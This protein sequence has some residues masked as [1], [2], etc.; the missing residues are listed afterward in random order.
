MTA[1]AL[2]IWLFAVAALAFLCLPGRAR[3][4]TPVSLKTQVS[5]REVEVSEPFTFTL[6]ALTDKGSS[7]PQ[8][9]SLSVPNGI[10]VRGPSVAMQQQVT[11]QGGSFQQKFGISATWTLEAQRP[12]R[13]R[14]GPASVS[15]GNQRASGDVIEIQVSPPGT[16][17]RPR[18]SD[19]FD[20]FGFGIPNLPGFPLG[21]DG[22]A[23]E[24]LPPF[25]EEL[26]LPQAEEPIAFLRAVVTPARAVVGQQVTLK[27]FAYGARGPFRETNTSEPSREA[28]LAHVIVENSYSETTHRVPIGGETWHA[29]KVR[30]VALFPIRTG[31]LVIGPMRMGFEGRGYP[32]TGP[33]R[34]LVRQSV[35]LTVEVVE[36]P[37]QRRPPGYRVG[38]VG[39]FA[40]S[41]NVEPRE[42]SAGDAVSVVAKLEGTGNL[43]L[44]LKTPQKTG[45]TWL[46]PTSVDEIEPRGSSIGGYR[47]LTYVV[48]IDTPGEVDLGELSLPYWD[49]ER[50]SYDV[51]KVPLGNVKVRPS[52][53]PAPN[54]DAKD[55]PL[56]GVLAPRKTLGPVPARSAFLG[57]R[58]A[59]WIALFAAPLGVVGIGTGRRL[60]Q[61]VF[62]RW[63]ERRA[64]QDTLA[65]TA[66][67][68]AKEAL[69]QG[70]HAEAA[71]QSE[72][73]VLAMLEAKLG[74]RARALLK[75]ELSARLESEG[76]DAKLAERVGELLERCDDA[77]FTGSTDAEGASALVAEAVSL[78]RALGQ[79]SK[80]P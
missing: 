63:N 30:E 21:D 32:S 47:K 58:L 40:L 57:D 44:D 15:V 19:P 41:A 79:T 23:K 77:R 31:K 18:G 28:F 26:R 56:A 43:P 9:P 7:L 33:H 27:I 62:R 61:R 2:R 70:A 48:R 51:A 69:Q 10:S 8:N 4:Q 68:R 1:R 24:D 29:K 49:P 45:V 54:T 80:K 22:D 67:S 37:E 55:D 17:P 72:R 78:V 5:S 6:T 74:I 35:P 46:E 60:G 50:E 36:P 52:A 3:A 64:S 14:I 53:G 38:D 11:L 75:R 20:P 25:P 65:K 71:S 42:I 73:A 59:Y 66:L 39:R 12:G 76:L 13:Y 16:R 34:G